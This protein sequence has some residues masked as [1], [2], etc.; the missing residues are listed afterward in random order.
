MLKYFIHCLTKI[1]FQF[2][3][4]FML[5]HIKLFTLQLVLVPLSEDADGS[6]LG[7]LAAIEEL[8][9]S[10][11]ADTILDVDDSIFQLR[12]LHVGRLILRH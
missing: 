6:L 5:F 8:D 10:D 4:T 11:R 12:S 9:I 2:P 1:M 7:S 3:T